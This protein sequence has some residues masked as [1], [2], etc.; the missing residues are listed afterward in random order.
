MTQTGTMLLG[1][2]GGGTS[3][4][5]AVVVR[6]QRHEVTLGPANVTTGFDAAVATIDTALRMLAGRA[7]LPPE[8]LFQA[9]A[10]LGLAGVVSA[11]LAARVRDALPLSRATVTD[12]RPTTIAGALG[13]AE[14]AVVAI[15]TGSF[16]GRQAGGRIRGIGGW[17]FFVGDQASGAWL[18]RRCLE[19]VMLSVDGLAAET[20][21]CRSLLADHGS[22]PAEIVRFS[23]AARPADYAGLARAVVAAAAAGDALGAR[24]MSEGADY[25]RRGLAALGWQRGETLCLTGGLGAAYAEWLDEP[26]V[27]ARGSALDGALSLAALATVRSEGQ[28]P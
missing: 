28:G 8:V 6:G 5:A 14:G 26:V 23:V 25:I 20:G 21:L 3:C 11:A 19:E 22:D 18:G 27:P 4:R 10:H 16:L 13:P 15:G 7:G 9:P 2:D 24:L 17:G 1:I 12:D